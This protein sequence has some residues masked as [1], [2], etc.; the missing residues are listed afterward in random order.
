M[1]KFILMICMISTL[2][3]IGVSANT[4]QL[5]DVPTAYTARAHHGEL[6]I[7]SN[8]SNLT[9][10]GVYAPLNNFDLAISLRGHKNLFKAYAAAKWQF[11]VEDSQNPAAAIGIGNDSIYAVVSRKFYP[12]LIGHLGVGAGDLAI[13]FAGIEYR[14]PTDTGIPPVRL[15]AEVNNTLNFGAI[16]TLAPAFDVAIAIKGL[17]DLHIGANFKYTF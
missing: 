16:A 1:K 6:V 5:V 7:W 14:L 8:F 10:K 2:F 4:R 12:S 13:V 3:V 11:L 15:V 9:A 17:S